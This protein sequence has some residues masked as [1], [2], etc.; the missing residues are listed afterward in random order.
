[1][2]KAAVLHE[3]GKPLVVE[4]VQ[5]DNPGPREVLVRTVI[6]FDVNA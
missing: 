1:M 6:T 5:I 3:V 4:D 2:M